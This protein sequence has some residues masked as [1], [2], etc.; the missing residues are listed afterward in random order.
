[1]ILEGPWTT[2]TQAHIGYEQTCFCQTP[3]VEKQLE[4]S[5]SKYLLNS[6]NVKI[7]LCYT[8]YQ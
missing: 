2:A 7:N 5:C 6:N 3:I 8:V 1:M 4:T